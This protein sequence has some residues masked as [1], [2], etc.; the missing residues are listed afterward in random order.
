MRGEHYLALVI[1]AGA[2]SVGCGGGSSSHQ[3]VPAG[4]LIVAPAS[5]NFGN[6]VV[7]Q[8]ATKTATLKA[9]NAGIAV[10]SADWKGEGYSV[11][12][13]SFP[14]TSRPARAFPIKSPSLRRGAA[15]HRGTSAS[16]AT[17]RTLLTLKRFRRPEV[18]PPNTPSRSPGIPSTPTLSPTTFI[19][20]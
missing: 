10:T 5:L 14:I 19:A 18:R 7:G 16:S 9:G 8:H 15:A 20:D 12:G 6:V 11:S 1:L 13:I 2:L 17:L 4:Q 3:D